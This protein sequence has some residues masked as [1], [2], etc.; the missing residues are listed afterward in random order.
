MRRPYSISEVPEEA[1]FRIGKVV[2]VDGRLVCVKVDKAKNTS[3]LLYKGQLV[4]NVSVGGYIKI[5][6]GF[7]SI[8][9]KVDGEFVEEDKYLGNKTYVSDKEKI[10]RTLKV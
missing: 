8:I 9:G 7:T 6:K 10:D 3:H 4:K 2:S 5:A 1:I